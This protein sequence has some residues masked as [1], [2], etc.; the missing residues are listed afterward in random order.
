MILPIGD[1]PNP[2]NYIPWMTWGLMALNIIIYLFIT[3]PLSTQGVDRGDPLLA[4]YIR[5]I[6]PHLP[7]G[8]SIQQ[9]LSQ[10]SA[11]ELFTFV[12]GY[13]PGAPELGDLFF[14]MFLHGG[15]LHLAGNMLF[16]W[17]YGNNV[18]H[19]L[20]R[21]GFLATYLATGAAATWFFSLI[22]GSSMIPLVG[23]SGAISGVLGVYF[24]LFPRNKVKML[25]A[26]IP[27]YVGVVL[28][29][30]R[31]V[32]GFYLVIDNL[33][34]LLVGPQSS[35]AYG[36]HIGGFLG[37]LAIAAAGER[38]SWHWPSRRRAQSIPGTERPREAPSQYSDMSN[39][40]AVRS[41]L[42]DNQPE[43]AVD[44]LS[45]MD[46]SE[47]G[48]LSPQECVMLSQWLDDTGHPVA[49]SRILKQCIS[50]HRGSRSLAEA[51][52][53]LGLL[54]LKEGQPTAAFQYLLAALDQDPPPETRQAI[55]DALSRINIYRS[56]R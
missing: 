24:L 12:H 4:E 53:S 52:L 51:Y 45:R 46:R 15:L 2:R 13:K 18:E 36:A 31:L 42:S 26:L 9:V 33:L 10:I 3:I 6:T 48:E 19:I 32:L 49:A 47:V 25:I 5:A 38:L 34:P 50:T 23:A 54:R 28:M 41:A 29:P 43:V 11:Y 21:P 17:I 30:A 14:S 35:V 56:G 44:I 16:L 40:S 55:E 39:L 37:G 20:G 27:F 7:S 1:T 22:S 8:V